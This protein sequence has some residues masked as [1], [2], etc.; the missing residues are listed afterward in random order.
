[1]VVLSNERLDLLIGREVIMNIVRY[2]EPLKNGICDECNHCLK[3]K[4]TKFCDASKNKNDKYID[5]LMKH[6]AKTIKKF[7]QCKVKLPLII[8]YLNET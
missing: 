4:R 6:A 7:S 2:D 5:F 1:M 3:I 8:E